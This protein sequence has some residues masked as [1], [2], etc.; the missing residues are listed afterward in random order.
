MMPHNGHAHVTK[1]KALLANNHLYLHRDRQTSAE[2]Q[3]AQTH[4]CRCITRAA[5]W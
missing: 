2:A 3:H 5:A 1:K 4:T